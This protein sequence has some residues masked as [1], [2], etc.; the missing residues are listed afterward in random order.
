M[1][2]DGWGDEARKALAASP[3]YFL[4]WYTTKS[5]G[6]GVMASALAFVM[7]RASVKRK[8]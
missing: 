3:N 7:G 5:I 8:T 6:L 1:S 4:W 2:I